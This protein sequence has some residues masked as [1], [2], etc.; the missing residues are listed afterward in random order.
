MLALMFA[1][2]PEAEACAMY[3]PQQQVVMAEAVVGFGAVE[4]GTLEDIFGMIDEEP[5]SPIEAFE[6]L[7]PPVEDKAEQP[8]SAGDAPVS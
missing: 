3:I 8:P 1:L 4:I 2:T 5:V 6:K 7:A